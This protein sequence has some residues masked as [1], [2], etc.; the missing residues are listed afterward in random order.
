MRDA[1]I[2]IERRSGLHALKELEACWT[3]LHAL[4]PRAGAWTHPSLLIGFHRMF[5][6]GGEPFVLAA[7]DEGGVL[8]GVLPLSIESKRVGPVMVRWAQPLAS[9]HS[10]FNDAVIDPDHAA[11]VL[12]ALARALDSVRW[13][14]LAMTR[15]REDAWLL[16]SSLG[17]LEH[18]PQLRREAGEP[19]PRVALQPTGPLLVG[20]DGRELRRTLRRLEELG[21]L[22]VGWESPGDTGREAT[23]EF[24][25]LHGRLKAYQRQTRTFTL[26]TARRDFPDWLAVESE[27]G[28]AGLYTARLNGRMLAGCVVLRAKARS[29]AY[30]A[31]WELDVAKYGMGVLLLTQAMVECRAAGDITFDLGPGREPY[32]NKWQ[33]SIHPLATLRVTRPT[34]RTRAANAW[35]RARGRA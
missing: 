17:F 9:W 29:F 11:A 13:D 21:T 16:D 3:A 34:W 23:A 20:P 32:K 25:A 30:R 33:P 26:G 24:V 12:P 18:I 8:R 10:C 4:D 19:A 28:R 14:E 15:V 27:V 35:L 1:S 5:R 22:R 7:H 6:P 2:I 31:A